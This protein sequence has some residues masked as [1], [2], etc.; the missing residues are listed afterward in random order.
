MIRNISYELLDKIDLTTDILLKFEDIGINK[1][2]YVFMKDRLDNFNLILDKEYST[3]VD[4]EYD[5]FKNFLLIEVLLSISDLL[6]PKDVQLE[7]IVN[8]HSYR[9]IN[10]Y[11]RNIQLFNSK[12]K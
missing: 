5:D 2:Q 4:L 6:G 7:Q 8:D 3:T 12:I 1:D 10:F 11:E 9:F